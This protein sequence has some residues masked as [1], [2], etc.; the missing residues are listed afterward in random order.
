[1]YEGSLFF[2]SFPAFFLCRLLNDVYSDQ[3]RWYLI[4]VLICISLIIRW[5]YFCLSIG[6]VFAFFEEMS[7][8]LFC[9]FFYLIFLLLLLSYV[10]CLYIL[11][12]KPLSVASYPDI[13]SQSVLSFHFVYSFLCCT[14]LISLIRSHLFIF[15]FIS[16][17]LGDWP[18]K[19]LINFMS[20]NV[21]VMFSYMSFMVPHLIFV[22]KP[23]WVYFCVGCESVF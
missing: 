2:I 13:F 10:S 18:K 4:I 16:I 19:T 8:K 21:L 9:P 3:L 14:K 17:A 6:H 7:I 11:E 23:S 20:E 5:A 22:F 12:I 1:M 15:A